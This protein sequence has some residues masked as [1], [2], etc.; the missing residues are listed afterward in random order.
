MRD[1]RA[2]PFHAS[3]SSAVFE[4]DLG[5]WDSVKHQ[6]FEFCPTSLAYHDALDDLAALVELAALD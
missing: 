4:M 6:G 3:P 1:F 2:D 5:V